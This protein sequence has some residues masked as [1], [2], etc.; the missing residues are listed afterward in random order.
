MVENTIDEIGKMGKINVD[1]IIVE[2]EKYSNIMND[3]FTNFKLNDSIIVEDKLPLIRSRHKKRNYDEMCSNEPIINPID[4]FKVQVFQ[5][6]IDQL[7][8]SFIESFSSNREIIADIQYVLPKNFEYAKDT[9]VSSM[10]RIKNI[11][12]KILLR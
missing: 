3:T 7:R 5:Y 2:T 4:K 8:S 9:E 12:Y 6:T 10:Y 11:I 1:P